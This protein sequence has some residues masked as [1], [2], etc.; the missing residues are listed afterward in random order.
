MDLKEVVFVLGMHRSGTS[1]VTGL[2]RHAGLELGSNLL[3]HAK[4]NPKGHFE[5]R[6][7]ININNDILKSCGGSW[8]APPKLQRIKFDVNTSKRVVDFLRGWKVGKVGLK[9]PR[10]CLTFHLWVV[11][12]RYLQEDTKIKAVIVQRPHEQIAHSLQKRNGFTIQQ[13]LKLTWLYNKALIANLSKT[14]VSFIITNYED[15]FKDAKAALQPVVDF[16][17]LQM[18]TPFNMRTFIDPKLWHNRQKGVIN[19][20]F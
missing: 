19:E 9:D 16:C 1:L 3:M 13:G 10:T 14:G 12:I 15:Y 18:P 7:F 17:G 5:D 20:P 11:A 8:R 4:D 2:L 6:K